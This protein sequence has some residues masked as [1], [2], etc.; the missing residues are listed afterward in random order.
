MIFEAFHTTKEDGTGL[1]LAI[2]KRIVEAHK[3]ELTEAPNP[4]GGASFRVRLP[5]TQ[6]Q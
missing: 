3:G 4:D 2:A 6:R 1:G 5:A